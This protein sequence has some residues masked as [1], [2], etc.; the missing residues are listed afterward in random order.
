MKPLFRLMMLVLFSFSL[1][2]N[3][4]AANE[5]IPS[6]SQAEMSGHHGHAHCGKMAT[7]SPCHHCGGECGHCQVTSYS[8]LVLI[9]SHSQWHL[10]LLAS[11]VPTTTEPLLLSLILDA[12]LRPPILGA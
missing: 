10:P 12:E 4:A 5:P 3:T 7:D 8:P 2:V 1:V 6:K 11:V 9:A